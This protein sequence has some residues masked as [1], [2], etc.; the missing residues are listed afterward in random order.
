MRIP[1]KYF[2]QEI[3]DQYNIMNIVDNNYVY[4]EIRKCMYGRTGFQLRCRKSCHTDIIQ[5]DTR[6][7]YENT[8]Q[9]KTKF[10]LCVDDLGIK[11]QDQNHLNNLLDAL[12]TKYQIFTDLT[13]S[14]YIGLTI[15]WKYD[16][17]YVDISMPKYVLKALQF[18]NILL[19]IDDNMPHTN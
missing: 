2:T 18:F 14:T 15:I 4:F 10:V 17:G 5:Y 12:Q 8:K 7:G 19:Q 16:K 1:L 9:K 3:R 6:Q 13:G 11:F